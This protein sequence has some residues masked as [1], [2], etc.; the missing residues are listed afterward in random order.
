MS[1][2]LLALALVAP[3]APPTGWATLQRGEEFIYRGTVSEAVDRVGNR[4]RRGHDLEIRVLVLDHRETWADIAVLTLLKRTDDTVS[5]T[6]SSLTGTAPER[7]PPATRLDLVRVH[8][9][10]SAQ[11]LLPSGPPPLLYNKDTPTRALPSLPLD[12]FAPFEFG[13]FAPLPRS[14]A[15]PWTVASS[16][17]GRPVETWQAQPA[18]FVNRVQCCKLQVVQQTATWNKPM[19]GETSWQRAE[20]VWVSTL[21]GTAHKVHRLLRHRDGIAESFAVT[22]EVNYELKKHSRI[23]DRTFDRS[24]CEV[25]IAFTAG[26]ELAALLPEAAKLGPKPFE[27]RLARIDKYLEESDPGTPYRAAVQAV[28]RQLEAA[29]KP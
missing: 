15:E 27:A 16:E 11:S 22:V 17:P 24:R 20:T 12:T 29:V 18:E 4:F 28:R 13:M 2:G 9:D 1:A 7:T 23:Y 19:G 8:A 25:E 26:S 14:A 5:G 21:D 3:A 6:V 10:G